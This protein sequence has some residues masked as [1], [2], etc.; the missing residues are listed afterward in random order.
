MRQLGPDEIHVLTA[1]A[2]RL[3]MGRKAYGPLDIAGDARDWKREATEE[4]LDLAVY[5]SCELLR[6]A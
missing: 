4:A 2:R 1:I 6:R 5:L 3:T